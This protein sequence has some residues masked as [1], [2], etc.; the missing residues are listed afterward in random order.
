MRI[1]TGVK[2]EYECLHIFQTFISKTDNRKLMHPCFGF[3]FEV[4]KIWVQKRS[5]TVTERALDNM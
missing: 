4:V 2:A 1:R 5:T 3:Y